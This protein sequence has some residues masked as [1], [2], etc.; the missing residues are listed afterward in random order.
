MLLIRE[1]G[2]VRLTWRGI[3]A[4]MGGTLPIALLFVYFGRFDLARPTLL[5]MIVIV[6]ALAMKWK[7]RGRVWFWVTM[8]AI[9]I[10]HVLLIVAIPWTTRWIPAIVATP[11]LAVDLA[12]ILVIVKVLEKLFEKPTRMM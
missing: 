7:L 12:T 4:V 6:V 3:L 8:A 1:D 9:A 11:I 10:L 5:S 2:Q